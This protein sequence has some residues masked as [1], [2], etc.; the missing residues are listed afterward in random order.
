MPQSRAG[1]GCSK[2][3]ATGSQVSSC[4]LPVAVC[5]LL[6]AGCTTA[7]NNS[8][9]PATIN[10]DPLLGGPPIQP[11][12]GRAAAP[13]PSPS[14]A[15]AAVPTLTAPS[16]STSTAALASGTAQPLDATHDLRIGGNPDSSPA[17]PS[18]APVPGT[19]TSDW[20]G[21]APVVLRGPEPATLPP[22]SSPPVPRQ[23]QPAPGIALMGG[24]R[25]MTFEQAQAQLRVRGVT[26]QRLEIWGDEGNWK[27]SCS[28]PNAQ[29]PAIRRS[30]E[31]PP[32]PDPLTAVQAVLDQIDRDQRQ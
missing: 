14:T 32:L 10:N 28:I 27:F 26:W 30:Y 8:R 5:L 19:P 31:S 25:V 24:T 17:A 21:Q 18:S 6:L 15:T 12:G 22:S 20:K 11:P 7:G 13:A 23:Q 9:P 3:K 29:N 4:L 16:T 1:T 2:Q